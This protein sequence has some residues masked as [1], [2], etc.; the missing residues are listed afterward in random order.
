HSHGPWVWEVIAGVKDTHESN[1]E[2]VIRE[3]R[4]ESGIIIDQES[5]FPICSYYS[6]PGGSDE[7]LQLYGAIVRLD[8]ME[9]VFGLSEENEDILFKTFDYLSAI[10]AM[11]CGEINNAATI[12]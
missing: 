10:N 3:I 9:N 5:L 7:R 4:E 8:D 6:S 1:E 2:V 11:L 12:I